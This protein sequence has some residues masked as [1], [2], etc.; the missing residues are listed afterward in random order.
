MILVFEEDQPSRIQMKM[1]SHD[2]G[3]EEEEEGE[4]DL[5][6]E[7]LNSFYND[8]SESRLDW[9]LILMNWIA[10][11]SRGI[12]RSSRVAVLI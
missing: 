5:L 12:E 11:L 6:K 9:I 7:A 10:E 1:W 3:E 4:V 8:M 2:Y